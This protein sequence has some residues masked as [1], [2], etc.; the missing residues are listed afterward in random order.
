VK[1]NVARCVYLA[2]IT[3]GCAV[4]TFARATFAKAQVA[5]HIRRV[6][7]GV[8]QSRKWAEQRGDS[9]TSNAQ[10]AKATGRTRPSGS[11]PNETQKQTAQHTRDDFNDALSDLDRSTNR[12]RRKFNSLDNWMETKAQM[13]QVMTTAE[14]SIRSWYGAIMVPKQRDIGPPCVIISM[15]WRHVTESGR[16]ARR[17]TDPI[18]SPNVY[19]T[20]TPVSLMDADEPS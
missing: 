3:L 8:D 9:A 14:G 11:T 17:R 1:K 18:P 16:W 12:L 6:A 4:S 15:A 10:T 7:D 2:L 19:L 13:Q 5:D 20:T